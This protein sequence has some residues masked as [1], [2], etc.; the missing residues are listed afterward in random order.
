MELLEVKN[1]TKSYFIKRPWQKPR[2][3]QALKDINLSLKQGETLAV[4]GESG[5]GKTTLAKMLMRIE[6]ST[7]GEILISGHRL[8]DISQLTLC[9][10]VQMIFQDPYSSLNPRK[11]VFD[12]IA[13]PLL[14][15]GGL[16]SDQ[17]SERVKQVMSQ[18]GLRPEYT[19]RYPHM[20][21]GGQ[22]QR[23]G[24]ARALVTRP[25][26]IIC[27]EPVSALDVSVQAQVLNLLK[28]IQ[29]QEK[30]SYIFISHD[31]SV[32]RFISHRVAVMY[33][34]RIVELAATAEIFD[35]PKHPYTQLLLKSTPK[36]HGGSHFEDVTDSAIELPSPINLPS[37]CA[38]HPRCPKAID[39]CK[40]KYPETRQIDDTL[41]ACHVAKS[42]KKSR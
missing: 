41:T 25:K 31:L 4:V 35:R 6:P 22:R 10:D 8:E 42:Q 23:I 28:D 17:I 13:E 14:V 19:V 37:G 11:K 32:V 16:S 40:L 21:S 38:F 26:V 20:F 27:D 2:P 1:L 5:S 36:L 34:G 15:R 30:I 18:V 3:L 39:I 24:I 29:R 33:L 7:S 12:I 9:D